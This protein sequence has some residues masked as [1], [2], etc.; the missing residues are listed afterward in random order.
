MSYKKNSDPLAYMSPGQKRAHA[1]LLEAVS[2][3]SEVG[4]LDALRL[5]LLACLLDEVR[6][7][8]AYTNKHGST[9]EVVGKSGDLYKRATP[10]HQQLNEARSKL[11]QVARS[12]TAGG[13]E[14]QQSLAELLA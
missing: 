7:L 2:N 8:Q 13:D 4:S 6:T 12:I 9:Y 10:E 14:V 1:Q 5:E 11:V 3:G